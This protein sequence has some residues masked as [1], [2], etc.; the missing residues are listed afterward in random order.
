MSSGRLQMSTLS[1]LR[2]GETNLGVVRSGLI[3]IVRVAPLST[4]ISVR[5]YRVSARQP[6]CEMSSDLALWHVCLT[7]MS[8][9]LLQGYCLG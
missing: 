7:V 8:T 2:V 4:N 5:N 6:S 9:C 1:G 3:M